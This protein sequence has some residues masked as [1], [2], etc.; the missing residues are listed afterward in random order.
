[1]G[2][3]P[4][5][6]PTRG[7]AQPRGD[8]SIPEASERILRSVGDWLRTSGECLTD[9]ELWTI[10]PYEKGDHRGDWISHGSFTA[11]GNNLYLIVTSPPPGSLT[12]S[13]L[14]ARVLEVEQL[15]S[16]PLEFSQDEDLVRIKGPATNQHPDGL[17]PVLR[18]RCDRPPAIYKTGGMR[19][20]Q[21]KHPRYDPVPSDISW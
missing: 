4:G 6:H 11:S 15:G 9:T 13:G 16:G 8:G 1:M 17:P 10:D 19:V 7:N 5:K 14:E 18:I 2:D 3:E 20:P 12:F 21:A